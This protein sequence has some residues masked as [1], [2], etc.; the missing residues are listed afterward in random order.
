MLNLRST[1][2]SFKSTISISILEKKYPFSF[3][4]EI[5]KSLSFF[6]IILLKDERGFKF[7]FSVILSLREFDLIPS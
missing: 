4:E 3:N 5:N 1:L 7:K 6:N 2:L